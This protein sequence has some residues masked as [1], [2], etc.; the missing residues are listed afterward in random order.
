MFK[1][2]I[3]I[4]RKIKNFSLFNEVFYTLLTIKNKK[5]RPSAI[6]ELAYL[7]CYCFVCLKTSFG[8]NSK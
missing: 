5:L 7:V 6:D 3:K 8:E 4:T 2:L 1:S